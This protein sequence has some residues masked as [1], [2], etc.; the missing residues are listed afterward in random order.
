M[1]LEVIVKPNSKSPGIVVIENSKWTVKVRERAIEG[2]ANKAVIQAISE[3]LKISKSKIQLIRGE[4]SKVKIFSIQ[5][6]IL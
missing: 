5:D 1:N 3:K 6:G 4:K 2:K